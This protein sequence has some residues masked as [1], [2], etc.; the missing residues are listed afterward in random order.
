MLSA[1]LEN[2][3]FLGVDLFDKKNFLELILR[4]GFNFI[5][6]FSI[7]RW[8]YYPAA[9][10]KDYL[11]TYILLSSIIFL[12]CFLLGN[13]KLQMGLVFGLFAVFGIIRYRT[14]AIPIK[15]MTYL[16]IIIGISVINALTNKK[17]S[18]AELLFTNLIMVGLTYGLEKV[19]LLRHESC[20]IITYEKID[21][22]KPE[23]RNELIEDLQNR[24][25]IKINR[26]EIG[27][28]D[29]L[30]DSAKILVYYFEDENSVNTADD[31]DSFKST[32]DD[33][34]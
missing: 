12:I 14:D 28:I 7:V 22:I 24:I 5:I 20:K 18:Y 34:D 6:I 2:L 4:F 30:R 17:V 13:V 8:M 29:F 27:R 25:G 32:G 9:K 1:W 3:K 15:E 31:L 21:L 23:R 33:D 19:W 16:F 10:R 26:I 11:F